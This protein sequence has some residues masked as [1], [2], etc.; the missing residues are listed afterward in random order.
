V[1]TP[2]KV[3]SERLGSYGMSVCK[4]GG[5]G[6]NDSLDIFLSS[7]RHLSELRR[8]IISEQYFIA[9]FGLRPRIGEEWGKVTIA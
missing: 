4:A 1:T 9:V 7:D 2:V 3:S 6:L 5:S 8:M